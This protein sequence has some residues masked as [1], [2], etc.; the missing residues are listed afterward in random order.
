MTRGK[1]TKR[2]GQQQTKE[3]RTAADCSGRGARGANICKFDRHKYVLTRTNRTNGVLMNPS[4]ILMSTN[5]V[6]S[7]KLSLFY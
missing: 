7:T 3:A 4:K 2:C 6:I 5:D 1:R